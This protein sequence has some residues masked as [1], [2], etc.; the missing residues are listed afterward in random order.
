MKNK[1]TEKMETGMVMMKDRKNTWN[2]KACS[3]AF[4][5]A[6][7]LA[8]S[9]CSV[10]EAI[11]P[12]GKGEKEYGKA[13]TMVVLTTERLRYEAVYTEEIWTASVDN[14]G[15]TFE[16]VL[17]PQVH[18]FLI[19]L[20]TMSNMAEEQEI[21]LTSK[22]KE[23]VHEAA[24]KYY[25]ELGSEHAED[26]G[27]KQE[28][29][30]ELYTDYWISEKL[31][32]Q[33]TGA[34]NLEVSD[35]EA[36][37]I[38]VSQMELSDKAKAEEVLALVQ[39]EDA[40]FHAIAKEYSENEEIKYQ[41]YRGQ[42]GSAYENAAFALAEGEVSGVISEDGRYY[43]LKCVD[44]YDEEATRIRKDQMMREKK[45]EAFHT[46]YQSYKAEHPLVVD[47]ELWS[48]LSVTDSPKVEADFFAIFEEV[49]G[50]Q[51]NGV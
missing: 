18:D 8:L 49:C 11:S 46:S 42:M 27:L 43:I 23:L 40:D 44:D 39:E 13:E 2:R 29:V 45:T 33:L 28:M 22:E 9:G 5:A 20:K 15:T 34:I 17:L 16:A 21:A 47:E 12:T 24:E 3:L 38:T 26:F 14:R 51:E 50:A 36:K 7:S 25:T 4:V 30:S 6:A 37:V 10:T 48:T 41:V 19:D 1:Q 35:S 31:V 32:E